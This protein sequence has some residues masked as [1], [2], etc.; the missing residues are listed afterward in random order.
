M[1]AVGFSLARRILVN[2]KREHLSM[3]FLSGP[4]I[5]DRITKL[6][7][8]TSQAWVAVPYLGKGAAKMLPLLAGSILITRFERSAIRAGQ[9]C[10]D[11]VIELIKRGVIVFNQPAL[12]AKIYIFRK[13]VILGSSNAS[14]TSRDR[15]IE[16]C[17]ETDDVKV[18]NEASALLL[19]MAQDEVDLASAEAMRNEYREP[20]GFP[21]AAEK[22]MNK[23]RRV[24]RPDELSERPL[25]LIAMHPR[26]S[27]E[28]AHLKAL[29]YAEEAAEASV[30][31]DGEGSIEVM[32][33]REDERERIDVGDIVLIRFRDTVDQIDE[34]HPPAK[35]LAIRKVRGSD[36][37]AVAYS[38]RKNARSR[39]TAAV[40]KKIG[41]K[42]PVMLSLK[43]VTRPAGP[44]E[45]AALLGLWSIKER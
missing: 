27:I 37:F 38:Q 36:E 15:L 34:L 12:H 8:T 21:L 23:K 40:G 24:V 19:N 9:V 41:K 7:A 22:E 44:E 29:D 11:D 14:H 10:P 6:A 2:K 39:D 26:R 31:Y 3:K 28:D 20:V 32:L 13:L 45:R 16:A 43:R 42:T 1:N 25:W 30:E 35:I 4:K 17:I 33:C 18:I 5:W